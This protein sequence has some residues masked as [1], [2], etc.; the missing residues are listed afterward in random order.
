[1]YRSGMLPDRSGLLYLDAP[2]QGLSMA[3]LFIM[4]LADW[5]PSA[6]EPAAT[7]DDLSPSNK[8]SLVIRS[9]CATSGGGGGGLSF[10]EKVSYLCMLANF[11]CFFN[12]C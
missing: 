5:L 7:A 11:I 3:G 1:M 2:P 8:P 6:W 12:V 4:S 9:F 10:S